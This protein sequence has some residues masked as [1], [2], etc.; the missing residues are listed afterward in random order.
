MMLLMR[1]FSWVFLSLKVEPK[2]LLP[3]F[4]RC[5]RVALL[6]LLRGLSPDS[7]CLVLVS[8]NVA[9][10]T[11]RAGKAFAPTRPA[12]IETVWHSFWPSF[13]SI[14]CKISAQPSV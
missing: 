3:H 7:P 4:I 6:L 13:A 8:L 11:V 9:Y 1:F 10:T 12:T 5:V 14:E 2:F